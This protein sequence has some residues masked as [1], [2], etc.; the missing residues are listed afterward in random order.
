M[1]LA[2]KMNTFI[3]YMKMSAF[4]N[5]V[6]IEEYLISECFQFQLSIE[7]NALDSC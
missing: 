5:K 6:K 2:L 7:M 4:L 1:S 3:M